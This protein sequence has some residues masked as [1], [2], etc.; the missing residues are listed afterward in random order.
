MKMLSKENW[1]SRIMLT[2]K[3]FFAH[4]VRRFWCSWKLCFIAIHSWINWLPSRFPEFLIFLGVPFFVE[5]MILEGID[6]WVHLVITLAV[7]IFKHMRA[8][9]VLLGFK[10]RML[11]QPLVTKTNSNT[12]NKSLNRIL[13]GDYK[14][15]W[16]G[17]SA[18]LLL[19]IYYYIWSVLWL[20]F[21]YASYPKVHASSMS[22]PCVH[23][24]VA[25]WLTCSLTLSSRLF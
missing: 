1:V 25:M 19:Y 8:W 17:V 11:W 10:V 7:D 4:F 13:S 6:I 12:S 20:C 2:I 22:A 14:R 9:F 24:E 3:L 15:T 21:Y 23:H 16:Q 5:A 18:E